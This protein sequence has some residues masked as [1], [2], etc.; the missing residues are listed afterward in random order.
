MKNTITTFLGLNI[1]WSIILLSILLVSCEQK[2]NESD[3]YG[4]FELDK[5]FIS[6]EAAGQILWL[7]IT[8]G[9][10]LKE[11][12]VIGQIDSLSLYYQKQQLL[13]QQKLILSNLP[14]VDAQIAIQ[15]QQKTN[16]IVQKERLQKLFK[17]QAATQKQLDDINGNYDLILTQISATKIRKNNIYE[18]AKAIDSQLATINYQ[19]TKCQII[20]PINGNVLNQLSRKGEM[21]APGKPLFSMATLQDIRLKVYVS[22][23]QLPQLKI[24]QKVQVLIDQ[25]KKENKM[26]E[27]EI[28]WIADEAEFTP[29]TVQTKEERVNLVYAV[30]IKIYNNGELKAGMPGEMIINN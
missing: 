2:N 28:V 20:C 11:Q 14:D 6:A 24:K 29:K 4:N 5:T 22:G 1:G 12:Q 19:I 23:A 13:A 7:D 16:V 17:K 21:A 8:E 26:L 10:S 30:K 18:Q 15:E 9:Q 3:A 27:G 25:N